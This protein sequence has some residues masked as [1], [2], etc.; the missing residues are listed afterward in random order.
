MMHC[1]AASRFH[2]AISIGAIKPDGKRESQRARIDV[3]LIPFE[4]GLES[5]ATTADALRI[6]LN[7]FFDSLTAGRMQSANIGS[8]A[9]RVGRRG[10]SVADEG[11]IEPLRLIGISAESVVTIRRRCYEL[12]KVRG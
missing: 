4:C 3:R 2:H 9:H 11:G 6:D 10:T 8:L 12:L 7:P 5:H 1:P